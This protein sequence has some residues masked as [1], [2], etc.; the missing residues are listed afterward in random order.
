MR[1]WATGVAPGKVGGFKRTPKIGR[2]AGGNR[3][4]RTK[5]RPGA[6]RMV[7][8]LETLA[9]AGLDPERGDIGQVEPNSE[10]SR[11]RP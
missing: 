3:L 1:C 5:F 4:I 8:E 6:I 2:T 9:I 11:A 7:R 10:A